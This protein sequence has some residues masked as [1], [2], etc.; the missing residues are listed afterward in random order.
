MAMRDGES[1]AEA[2]EKANLAR[3]GKSPA[4]RQISREKANLAREGKSR[5]RKQIS[6]EKANLPRIL[7]AISG[8]AATPSY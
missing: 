2:R 3:E 1:E 7:M 5:A 6:R 8:E 4:R